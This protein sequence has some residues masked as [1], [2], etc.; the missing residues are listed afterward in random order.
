M[1]IMGGRENDVLSTQNPLS[2]GNSFGDALLDRGLEVKVSSSGGAASGSGSG[3][4]TG[5]SYLTEAEWTQIATL[6]PKFVEEY[7]ELGTGGASATGAVVSNLPALP[8]A[9]AASPGC[10][11]CRRGRR[12][13]RRRLPGPRGTSARRRRPGRPDRPARPVRRPRWGRTRC[14]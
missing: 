3:L 9:P 14:R 12:S 8:E 2:G 11:V 1:A 6:K 7:P 5:S 4:L 13:T 10:P